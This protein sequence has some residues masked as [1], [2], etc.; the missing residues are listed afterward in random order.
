MRLSAI[1]K[2]SQDV[3]YGDQVPLFVY[4]KGV[5]KKDVLIALIAG[6]FIG[7]INNRADCIGYGFFVGRRN[8]TGYCLC[9]IDG[10]RTENTHEY[11]QR[12]GGFFPI[13]SHLAR[14]P[15]F[16]SFI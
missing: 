4:E 6:S 1:A 12:L 14:N 2:G 3:G 9:R 11:R 7:G 16:C 5:A 10:E 13:W 8:F 15:R